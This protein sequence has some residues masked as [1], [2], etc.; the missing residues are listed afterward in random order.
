M[1]DF[2]AEPIS[3]YHSKAPHYGEV[4]NVVVQLQAI[5]KKLW[6]TFEFFDIAAPSIPTLWTIKDDRPYKCRLPLWAYKRD[7]WPEIWTQA[8]Q[9]TNIVLLSANHGLERFTTQLHCAFL[10][11]LREKDI[12]HSFTLRWV[13][14]VN[15][16]GFLYGWRSNHHGVDLLRDYDHQAPNPHWVSIGSGHRISPKLP[17][18][19]WEPGRVEFENRVLDAFLTYIHKQSALTF[20]L[21]LHTWIEASELNEFKS[22]LRRPNTLQA[23]DPHREYYHILNQALTAAQNKEQPTLKHKRQFAGSPYGSH[24]DSADHRHMLFN[25]QENQWA[26]PMLLSTLEIPMPRRKL[27]HR[28]HTLSKRADAIFNPPPKIKEQMLQAHLQLMHVL[29]ET[30]VNPAFQIMNR[31]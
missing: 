5:Q 31:K 27:P 3:Y 23:E 7:I 15:M 4:D 16:S 17:Y 1:E 10:E 28:W 9:H 8:Q 13:P 30:V 18:Y 12:Q 14:I 11:Q 25:T 2:Y 20:V 6:A 19:R 22:G 29:V 26:H 24:G 21:D